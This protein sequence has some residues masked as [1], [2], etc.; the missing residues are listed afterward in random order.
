MKNKIIMR[1]VDAEFLQK[2]M[3]KPEQKNRGEEEKFSELG[4]YLF[5]RF[6]LHI[7]LFSSTFYIQNEEKPFYKQVSRI[8]R[9]STTDTY[10]HLPQ[11]KVS[12]TQP[13]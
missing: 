6:F 13:K 2:K 5:C 8:L 11:A 4:L 1:K 3:S 9:G 12:K 7:Q 10:F